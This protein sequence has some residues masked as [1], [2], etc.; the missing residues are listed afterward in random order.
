MNKQQTKLIAMQTKVIKTACIC[1]Y[2]ELFDGLKFRNR[3]ITNA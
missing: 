1:G 3:V 2:L